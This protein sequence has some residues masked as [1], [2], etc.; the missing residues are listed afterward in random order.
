LV[1]VWGS[2]GGDTL[3]KMMFEMEEV[4]EAT[5]ADAEVS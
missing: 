2:I 3:L 1:D 5:D 4:V